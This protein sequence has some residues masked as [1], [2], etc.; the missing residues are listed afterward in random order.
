MSLLSR[1]NKAKTSFTLSDFEA[2]GFTQTVC[3]RVSTLEAKGVTLTE[4]ILVKLGIP[5]PG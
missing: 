5:L 4:D 3:K 1:S 2:E